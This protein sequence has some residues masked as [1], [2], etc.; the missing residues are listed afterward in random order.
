MQPL[1]LSSRVL[2]FSVPSC[3]SP[4]PQT[5]SPQRTW[6]IHVPALS[7]Q[8]C[9]LPLTHSSSPI[10]CELLKWSNPCHIHADPAS[11]QWIWTIWMNPDSGGW[12]TFLG[13]LKIFLHCLCG[14][15]HRRKHVCCS[16]NV[17]WGSRA[18]A[19]GESRNHLQSIWEYC[20]HVFSYL[21]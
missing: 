3:P 20:C 1:R 4:L 8:H 18:L 17:N 12:P 2:Q 5:A 21:D 19:D 13:A 11:R 14:A 10:D 9:G 6:L 15:E 16:G 7:I